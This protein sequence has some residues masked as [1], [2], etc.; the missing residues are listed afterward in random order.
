[1]YRSSGSALEV[2][3]EGIRLYRGHFPAFFGSVAL[4]YLPYYL[5]LSLLKGLP[6]GIAVLWVGMLGTL[7]QVLATVVVVRTTAQVQKGE[8]VGIGEALGAISVGV[9]GRVLGALVP[10]LALT[11]L[12]FFLLVVP[13]LLFLVWF[14]FSGQVAVLEGKTLWEALRRSRELVRGR[15]WRVLYLL[16]LFL[17]ANFLLI[18]IPSKLFPQ[19]AAPAGQV[20]ALLFLPFP[21]IVMTLLYLEAREWEMFSR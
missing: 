16:V 6:V 4:I 12:G 8:L 10:A 1:M 19:F 17:A 15:G 3:A 21:I 18:A 5:V 14:A 7:A 20:L 2:L 13:G 11:A 9:V